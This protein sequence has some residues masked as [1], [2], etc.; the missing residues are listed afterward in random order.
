[1]ADVPDVQMYD[2]TGAPTQ[3][4]SLNEAVFGATPNRA[5]LHQAVVRQLANARQ[6][7]HD[8]Q[9]RAEVSRTTKKVWRQKGT[10]R[11]RQ[12]SR[13]APHWRGGGVVFGP[14]PRSYRQDLPKK[15]RAGALRSALAAKAA[16][17]EVIVLQE[18][19]MDAP[20]TKGL[21][22]LLGRVS[23][24]RSQ[25]LILDAPQRALQL[26]ARN[27]PQVKVITTENVSVVDLLRYEHL[28]LSLAALR[29]LEERY[30]RPPAGRVMASAGA[31][32][33]PVGRTASAGQTPEAPSSLVPDDAA[34]T[35][36]G[37][38]VAVVQPT[39]AIMLEGPG[40]GQAT[41]EGAEDRP[42]AADAVR[43]AVS[44]G[45]AAGEAGR[46]VGA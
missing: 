15:M 34:P 8:T 45:P 14:H 41:L 10:G 32:H 26:S 22:Q 11:A 39:A 46:S 43:P 19:L 5:L 38:V 29:R 6:G 23:K 2:A 16:A 25:L 1:M 36:P 9:T 7:T 28:V 20:S 44:T 30:A 4:V 13:K 18:L 21:A 35:A 27:L 37:V 42:G 12:G 40:E 24:G 17:G 33:E 31:P 3:T